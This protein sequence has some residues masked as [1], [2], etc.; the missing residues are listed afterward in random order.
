VALRR[1]DLLI[2]DCAAL[3]CA[4]DPR[5]AEIGFTLGRAHQGQGY[6]TEAVRRLLDYLLLE[7]GKY[8]VSASCDARNMRSAALLERVGMRREGHLRESTWFNGE[9]T[10]D[11]LYAVL[12]REWPASR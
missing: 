8:R 10:S 6:G 2:G 3:V 11:L 5:Q 7:R 1:T 9:W 12:G 4:D